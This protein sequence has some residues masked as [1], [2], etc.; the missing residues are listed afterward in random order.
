MFSFSVFQNHSIFKALLV[1]WLEAV[2]LLC[3]AA[4]GGGGWGILME[5]LG[6]GVHTIVHVATQQVCGAG[7]MGCLRSSVESGRELSSR[8]AG[9]CPYREVD[10]KGCFGARWC[11]EVGTVGHYLDREAIRGD[12]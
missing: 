11:L 3:V 6:G 5:W 8:A 12:T 4:G 7:G 9:V 1:I 10:L 2:W